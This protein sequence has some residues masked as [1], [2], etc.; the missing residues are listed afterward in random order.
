[1]SF[2]GGIILLVGVPVVVG[3][4]LYVLA[5]IAFFNLRDRWRGAEKEGKKVEEN[6]KA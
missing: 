3:S 4:I 5:D 1:M 2:V 6:E